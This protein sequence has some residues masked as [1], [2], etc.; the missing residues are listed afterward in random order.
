LLTLQVWLPV[1]NEPE[2]GR[3]FTRT[4]RLGFFDR[5]VAA[6]GQVPGVRGV[7]LLSRLPFSAVGVAGHGRNDV[8]FEIEGHPVPADQ[9]RPMAEFGLVSPNFFQTMQIPLLRRRTL[10]GV[11]DSAS[12]GEVV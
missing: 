6:V 7:S 1:Q 4:Q 12:P 10:S 8:R 5:S 2:K 9:L 3:Y 11:T